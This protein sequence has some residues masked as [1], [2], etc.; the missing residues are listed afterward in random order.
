V[1]PPSEISLINPVTTISSELRKP[2]TMFCTL[3]FHAVSVL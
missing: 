2:A 3:A 1:T